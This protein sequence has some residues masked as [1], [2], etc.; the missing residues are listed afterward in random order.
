[1]CCGPRAQYR[2]L[3]N[4][5]VFHRTSPLSQDFAAEATSMDILSRQIEGEAPY[6]DRLICFDFNHYFSPRLG[7]K[8]EQL[9]NEYR[10][11]IGLSPKAP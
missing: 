11:W 6:V 5:E 7:D 4:C 1:R 10:A 9:Y 3:G 8:A 2:D